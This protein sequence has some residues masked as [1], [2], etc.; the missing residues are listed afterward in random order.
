MRYF[1]ILSVVK[2]SVT[3]YYLI[4]IVVSIYFSLFFSNYYA[5][6]VANT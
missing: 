6:P 5:C 4:P 1:F 3:L 2:H